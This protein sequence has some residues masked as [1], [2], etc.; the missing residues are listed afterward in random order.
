MSTIT[1]RDLDDALIAATK[2]RAADNGV[3]IEE[4]MGR[5]LTSIYS[6]TP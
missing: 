1:V 5:I 3:S 4:G 2:R 6:G